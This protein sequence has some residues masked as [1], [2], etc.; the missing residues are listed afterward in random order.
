MQEP[1]PLLR[2][3]LPD[4]RELTATRLHLAHRWDGYYAHPGGEEGRRL[5]LDSARREAIRQFGD[6]APVHILGAD[7]EDLDAVPQFRIV[8]DFSS[9]PKSQGFHGSAL[10]VA[11]FQEQPFPCPDEAALKLIESTDWEAL[12]QDFC[13]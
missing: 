3:T 11:W 12:A 8:A 6:G 5:L 9:T 2:V 10:N 1:K 7:T 13:W 4:G